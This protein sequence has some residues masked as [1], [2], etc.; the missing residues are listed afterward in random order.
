MPGVLQGA[1]VD[2]ALGA[3][4]RLG[5]ETHMLEFSSR[6][7]LAAGSGATSSEDR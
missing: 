5:M 1:A 3:M 4:W 2:A 7:R 6:D